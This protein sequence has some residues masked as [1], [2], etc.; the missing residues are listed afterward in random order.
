MKLG[1][2]DSILVFK[3]NRLSVFL[4]IVKAECFVGWLNCLDKVIYQFSLCFRILRVTPLEEN[5]LCCQS[6]EPQK[7]SFEED[8]AGYVSKVCRCD[9][10]CI[11]EVI[12]Q[13]NIDDREDNEFPIGRHSLLVF[14]SRRRLLWRGNLTLAVIL[15]SFGCSVWESFVREAN[16]AFLVAPVW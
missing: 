14:M 10:V 6:F 1:K 11:V 4:S 8:W 15:T 16:K 9:L 5:L 12:C 13:Q 3:P 2:S 7:V